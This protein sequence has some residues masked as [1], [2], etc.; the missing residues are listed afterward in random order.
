LLFD[1]G[2]GATFHGAA[3]DGAVSPKLRSKSES[4]LHADK[5]QE[6]TAPGQDRY[7]VS[8]SLKKL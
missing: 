4:M 1:N 8:T 3:N 2:A 6:G 7:Q 5:P